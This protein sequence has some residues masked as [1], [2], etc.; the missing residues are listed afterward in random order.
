MLIKLLRDIWTSMRHKDSGASNASKQIPKYSPAVFHTSD[1]EKAK[2]IILTPT[3]DMTTDERWEIETRRL[4]DELGHALNLN[5]DSRILDFGCGIG[6]IAKALIERYGCTVVG[7]DISENMR[8]LSIDYVKSER[9]I[10][11]DPAT[12]DQMIKEGFHATGAY[13][14]WVLQHCHSPALEIERIHSALVPGA[15]LFVLNSNNRLV[16]TDSGWASDDISVEN[17]LAARFEPVSKF[18]VSQLVVSKNLAN[19][20]YGMLLK[21]RSPR[22]MR[23]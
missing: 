10:A 21:A 20:S 15:P 3:P 11:C 16:P 1:I 2:Y 22:S 8:K 13:T 12:F 23:S 17:L 14:C 5:P 18:D 4:S 6:R 19:Q 9:F 7:V